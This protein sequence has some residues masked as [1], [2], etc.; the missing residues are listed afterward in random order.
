MI[1]RLKKKPDNFEEKLER[2][3]YSLSI[4]SNDKPVNLFRDKN[5]FIYLCPDSNS[6]Y[7]SSD[8][9]TSEDVEAI[10]NNP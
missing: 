2:Y 3:E 10:V 5:R 7:F 8:E 1:I 9:K 6:I 4:G